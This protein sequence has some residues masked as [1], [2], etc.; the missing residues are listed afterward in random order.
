[1][2]LAVTL[3]VAAC[4]DEMPE[5]VTQQMEAA[6]D[7]TE[8]ASADT[9]P[10]QPD[11]EGLLRAA[12]SGTH[13]DWIRDIRV[14]LDSVPAEAALDR[15]DALHSV[16]E[17]YTRR[18]DALRIFYGAGGAIDAGAAVT[19]AVD[20]ASTHLQELMRLLATDASDADAI[21]QSVRSSQEALDRVGVATREAGV[22]RDSPRDSVIIE[23]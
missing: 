23:G 4:A 1:M 3:V 22:P 13:V 6:R 11:L 8:V 10:A 16:Q 21:E 15:G 12:P 18:F 7:S 19:Q 2:W 17:L 9:A 5:D 14:G 20:D